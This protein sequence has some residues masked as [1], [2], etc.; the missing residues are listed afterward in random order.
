MTQVLSPG[1]ADGQL[2]AVT[3]QGDAADAGRHLAEL[4]GSVVRGLRGST[5]VEKVSQLA[6]YSAKG[7]RLMERGERLP[8]IDRY[9]KILDALEASAADFE[10]ALLGALLRRHRSK[11]DAGDP[12]SLLV[13]VRRIGQ[14]LMDL[15]NL[16]AGEGG[17]DDAVC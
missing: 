3:S 4:V 6:G 9:Q 2:P 7:W 10:G 1:T 15:G 16:T 8:R 11:L 5:S 14:R 13:E 17:A 12:A